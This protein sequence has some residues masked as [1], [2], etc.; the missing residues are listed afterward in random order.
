MN[1][2]FGLERG[3]INSRPSLAECLTS[4]RDRDGFRAASAATSTPTR[5]SGSPQRAGAPS[6]ARY[7]WMREKKSRKRLQTPAGSSPLQVSSEITSD[8]ECPAASCRRLRTAYSNTQLLELEK[9][10]HFNKY[11]CRPRRLE[12]A[13][14]LDVSEKQVK[15]WFQNRRMKHKRQ[16]HLKEN[17]RSQ[18]AEDFWEEAEVL[19]ARGE[20]CFQQN[21]FNSQLSPCGHNGDNDSSSCTGGKNAKY[22]SNCTRSAPVWGSSKGPDDDPTPGARGDRSPGA[23]VSL[24]ELSS[25]ACP[26]SPGWP[27]SA[28]SPLALSP[29]TLELFSETLTTMEAQNFNY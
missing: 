28:Q 6:A 24:R 13:S 23:A 22:P 12:I 5:G 25:G 1:D 4:P 16:T 14:S 21:I 7:P 11:L 9:E 15:V 8:G 10:F 26:F 27:S 19:Q 20:R 2:A 17:R 3:F 29:E 18:F